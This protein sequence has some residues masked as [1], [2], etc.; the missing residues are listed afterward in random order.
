VQDIALVTGTNTVLAGDVVTFAA[1]TTN[2]YV[3]NTGVAAPGTIK[4]GR[5]GAKVTIATANAMTIGNNYTANLAFERN[6]VVGIMRPP[7]MPP[8]PLIQ[9]TYISDKQGLTYLLVQIAGDGMVTWRLHLCYGFKVVQSEH[10][11]IVMG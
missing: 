2:K 9:S 7:V 11:A 3:I 8:N 4:L 6:A 10:V 5:P 1:D